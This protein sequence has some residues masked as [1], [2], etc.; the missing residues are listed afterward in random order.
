MEADA[1]PVSGSALQRV[2]IHVTDYKAWQRLG[3]GPGFE[4]VASP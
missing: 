4:S 1:D 2:R 3:D